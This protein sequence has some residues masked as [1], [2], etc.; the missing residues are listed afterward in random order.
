[1]MNFVE[2][3][4]VEGY[5]IV[6]GVLDNSSVQR[7]IN[8]LERDQHDEES[9]GGRRN[10][11]S[12]PEIRQLAE[13]TVIKTLIDPVLGDG[14]F[15]VRGILFDKRGDA[16]WKVPWHQDVTIAVRERIPTPDYG[17][18]SIKKSVHHVQPP[19][20][21]LEQ[22]ISVRLHLDD[23]P[24]SNGALKVIAGTHRFGR[25]DQNNIG[26]FISL[27]SERVC[28]SSRGGALLMRPLLIHASS[29]SEKPQHRRVIHFDYA[30]VEL[31]GELEWFEERK[32][33]YK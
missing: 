4:E 32:S 22:M 30:N 1:M 13:S 16:N 27:Q 29:C 12:V 24:T 15:P 9:R 5:A 18:W 3:V 7:Y 20:R 23:C 8:L 33:A 14:A 10:L 21:V 28:E 19:T 11:L 17:P 31:E 25:L 26:D 2:Q 6:D